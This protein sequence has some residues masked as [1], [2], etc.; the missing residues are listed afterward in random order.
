MATEII[1][2]P[3]PNY[4]QAQLVGNAGHSHYGALQ[5][6]F[7][8]SWTNGLQALASYTWAHSID[9][10][11]YGAY[12]NGSFADVN[13]NRGDSDFDIRNAFSAALTYNVPTPTANSFT[14]AILGGW[15][16][17]NIF[18]ASSA[19]PVTVNDTQFSAFELTNASILIRPDVVPGQPL[20]LHDS[21]YPG[22]KALNPEAFRSPPVGP[23]GSPIRQ[24]DLGRSSLRA[25]GLTQWNF[26]VH[27][28]FP[29]HESVK[30]QFR[31]ELFNVLNHP[32]FAP[33]DVSFNPLSPDPH[34]G[35][36]T[37][38]LGQ[39]LIPS[40]L[41]GEGGQSPLYNVGAPRSIQLALK[42]SF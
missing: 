21:L 3:N 19:P 22:R 4:L 24:G 10:G 26:A 6:Q 16:T 29:I 32:S 15:S 27:R 9:T 5:V 28:E 7:Q 20:Y 2:N 42:L 8:R 11:S 1:N 40:G 33:Y 23:T 17:E 35:L 31:S 30:L 14:K 34:F 36:A 18:Q 37:Q 25:F 41:V 12:A 39:S 13:I 38:L